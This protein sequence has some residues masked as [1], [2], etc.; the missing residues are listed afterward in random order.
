MKPLDFSDCKILC[1]CEGNFEEDVINFLLEHNKLKFS[2]S[3]L[4]D[5]K[6]TRTRK[7]AKIQQ[8]FLNRT[9][10]QKIIILRIIDS[11]KEGFKLAPAYHHK[12]K[13]NERTGKLYTNI[14]TR[15]E[16]EILVVIDKG[17]FTK[18]Q[19]QR[20]KPSDFCKT[21]YKFDDVKEVGF[22]EKYFVNINNLIRVIKKYKSFHSNDSDYT[23]ADLLK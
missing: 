16:I 15:P 17:D 7:A 23:L 6:V 18:F 4:V 10:S 3:D 21:E 2:V 5:E 20:L 19:N 11:K 22:V 9:Y 13:I 14:I 8:E 12:V 1:I